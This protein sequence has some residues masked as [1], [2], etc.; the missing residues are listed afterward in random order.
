MNLSQIQNKL[1]TSKWMLQKSELYAIWQQIENRQAIRVGGLVGKIFG[2][3]SFTNKK[4]ALDNKTTNETTNNNNDNGYM[5]VITISGILIKGESEDEMF[6]NID[7]IT[8]ELNMVANDNNCK[9][10]LLIFNS[11]GG[12]TTGIEELGRLINNIDTILKPVYAWTE[13][14]MGS[15]ALWLG[16]QARNIGM[17]YSA[18][19]GSCGVYMMLLDLTKQLDNEGIKVNAFSAGKYKLMGHEFKPLD[20]D[21]KTILQSN[22]DKQHGQFKSVILAKRP[23]V[24]SECLEGL[25]YEGEDALVNNLVDCVCDNLDEYLEY[26]SG[27]NKTS[28]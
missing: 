17:T 23:K 16:S 11:P 10:I 24:N 5:A 6:T 8:N 2:E 28:N 15:A 21:E 1:L 4:T 9:S 3:P 25:S 14:T 19:I 7:A 26:L 20:N 12:E 27:E 13:T 18:T 22:V